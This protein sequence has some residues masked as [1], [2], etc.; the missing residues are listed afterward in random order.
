M[1]SIYSLKKKYNFFPL[2]EYLFKIKHKKKN[3]VVNER[4]ILWVQIYLEQI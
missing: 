2:E 1:I 4:T 3:I